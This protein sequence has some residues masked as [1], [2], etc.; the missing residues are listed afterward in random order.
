MPLKE[1][2]AEP[3][4]KKTKKLWI[5]STV[6]L[7]VIV[8]VIF[9][10][11]G[12]RIKLYYV[13]IKKNPFKK[14]DK[15]YYTNR[16]I[17]KGYTIDIYQTIEPENGGSQCL[18]EAKWVLSADSLNKYKTSQIGTYLDY[19]VINIW[20]DDKTQIPMLMYAIKVNKKALYKDLNSYSTPSN[21]P[22]GYKEVSGPF[23]VV[24]GFTRDKE[25][26]GD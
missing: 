23:Y 26:N 8:I 18:V 13:N 3:K 19:K 4:A 15:V 16:L 25:N 9:L 11:Q 14:G 21:I 1:T 17:K 12:R 24:A 5:I 7:I 20:M 2:A 6:A 10:T 22:V